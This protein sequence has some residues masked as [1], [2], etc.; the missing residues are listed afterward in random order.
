[1]KN[2]SAGQM[3]ICRRICVLNQKLAVAYPSCD[4]YP[5]NN[6]LLWSSTPRKNKRFKNGAEG[7]INP[8]EIRAFSY[9]FVLIKSRGRRYTY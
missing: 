1:M 3:K 9:G 2:K 7:K 6:I 5:S 8:L 4:V